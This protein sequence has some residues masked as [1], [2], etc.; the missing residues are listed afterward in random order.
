MT[1]ETKRK[2]G[3]PKE[4]KE[5]KKETVKASKKETTIPETTKTETPTKK[6][7]PGPPYF[8]GMRKHS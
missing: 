6:T 3:D 2:S 1:F 8:T 7:L 5:E 4:N